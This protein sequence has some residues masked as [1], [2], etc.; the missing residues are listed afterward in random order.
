MAL[1]E[2]LLK[3]YPGYADRDKAYYYLVDT[4]HREGKDAEAREAL[5]TMSGEH[6]QSVFLAKAQKA[7][8]GGGK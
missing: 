5:T 3:A 1:I 4:L 6:A 2:R 8:G 7:L